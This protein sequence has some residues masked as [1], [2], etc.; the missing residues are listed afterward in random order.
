VLLP[1][2]PP[3]FL[4]EPVM[5]RESQVGDF[6]R[7]RI[8]PPARAASRDHRD[9]APSTKR[10]QQALERGRINGV[11]HYMIAGLED[12][13]RVGLEKKAL[14]RMEHAIRVDCL[15]AL[16]QNFHLGLPQFSLQRVQLTVDIADTDVIKVHQGQL[17]N[18]RP[19]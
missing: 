15:H 16:G 1:Q 10:N 9:A 13:F 4:Q 3:D 17:S 5:A 2:P 6:D 18:P 19:G 14:Q 12:F 11:E 7:G 8:A